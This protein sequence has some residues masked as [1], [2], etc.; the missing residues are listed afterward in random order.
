LAELVGVSPTTAKHLAKL[1]LTGLVRGRR[2][3]TFVYYTA[4]VVTTP[5]SLFLLPV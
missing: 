3:G 1:R 4:V 5:A 2:Q